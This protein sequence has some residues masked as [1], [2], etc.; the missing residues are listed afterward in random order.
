MEW[1]NEARLRCLL[2]SSQD[3][4]HLKTVVA[5]LHAHGIQ[6]E[7]GLHRPWRSA[8]FE[9]SV[10]GLARGL[11]K[12]LS[13][14]R[15]IRNSAR[16]WPYAR[17]KLGTIEADGAWKA[18]A[19][20]EFFARHKQPEPTDSGRSFFATKPDHGSFC[21]RREDSGGTRAARLTR[22]RRSVQID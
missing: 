1:I 4:G 18:K 2:V 21:T 7:E 5:M 12:G 10:Y 17:L 8:S 6:T 13:A 9:S 19:F 11:S 20:P 14:L 16:D 22:F 15:G 3:P